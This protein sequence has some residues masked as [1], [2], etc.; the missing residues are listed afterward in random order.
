MGVRELNG[1]A[2]E[3][4]NFERLETPRPLSL[5]QPGEK[6]GIRAVR[7]VV[8]MRVEEVG[9]QADAREERVQPRRWGGELEV[10]AVGVG[11]VGELLE[12]GELAVEE[13]ERVKSLLRTS[14]ATLV[15]A[16]IND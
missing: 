5:K 14:G 6:F 7:D 12:A 2:R 16:V 10:S 13:V 8:D 15:G 9:V 11:L 3:D 4:L 1:S